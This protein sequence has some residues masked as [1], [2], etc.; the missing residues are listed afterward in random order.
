MDVPNPQRAPLR[1]SST[2]KVE[3]EK[4]TMKRGHKSLLRAVAALSVTSLTA[5]AT[6]FLTAG[7]AD[8]ATYYG[9]SVSIGQGFARIAVRTDAAGKPVSVEVRMSR[10][11]LSELPMKPSKMNKEGSWVYS[12]P[13]PTKGPKTGYTK[14]VIDWNPNGHPPPHIYTVP[15]FDFHFYLTSPAEVANVKFTGP[16]DPATRVSDAG[17]VPA[18]YKVIPDTAIDKMGVHAVDLAAPEFHGK[19]FTATFIYG[20]YKGRLTFLE[21]MIT[22]AYLL[23]RPNKNWPVK[24]PQRYSFAAAYPTGYSV[25]YEAAHKAYVISLDGLKYWKK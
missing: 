2:L 11:A 17:L 24:T 3:K 16:S 25:R 13:M 10:Y 19:S 18:G 4:V 8:A 9:K 21:P 20:Y 1:R 14:V 7:A 12:L 5:A 15:H 23:K 22:R 6:A